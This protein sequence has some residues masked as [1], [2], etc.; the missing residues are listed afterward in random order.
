MTKI[1]IAGGRDFKMY[2]LLCQALESLLCE[3]N[4]QKHE[5]TIVSGG[6][7][8]ADALG[9]RYAREHGIELVIFPADWDTYGNAAGPI[10]NAEMADYADY[11][12][13]FW[14]GKSRGTAN[15]IQAMKNRKKHGK[16]I[17]Y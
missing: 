9:E 10:R 3:M 4:L 8:G 7:R 12:L 16:V 1:I 5:V 14:D 13:A 17:K 15:M 11:L 6:A 2:D